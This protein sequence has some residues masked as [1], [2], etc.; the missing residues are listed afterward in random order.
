MIMSAVA[1]LLR[2]EVALH[3]PLQ[4]REHPVAVLLGEVRELPL[5]GELGEVLV[6]PPHRVP[7]AVR[8]ALRHRLGAVHERVRRHLVGGDAR[9][10]RGVRGRRAVVARCARPS[11]RAAA[12]SRTTAGRARGCP[13]T[14]ALPSLVAAIQHGGCGSCTGLGVTMRRG[15][16]R[17]LPWNSKYSSSHMRTTASI[18]SCHW[19]RLSSR[20]ARRTRS[21]PSG[22]TG[23]CPTRP[24]RWTGCRRS[25]PSRPRAS[26]A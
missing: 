17:Y 20:S 14:A 18:A 23:R 22:S 19:S 15:K 21:A 6:P 10:R 24:A 7:D 4:E 13:A 16:S 9:D 8:L 5:E 3:L 26:A 1:E 11:R 25:R 12:G 2:V